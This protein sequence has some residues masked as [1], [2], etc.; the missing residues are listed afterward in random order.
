MRTLRALF[1]TILMPGTVVVVI[2]SM[3]LR[4]EAPAGPFAFQPLRLQGLILLVVG[5][6]ALFWCI[7]DFAVSG[8]GT[9]APVDPPRRLVRVGLYRYV[10]NPMYVAVITTLVG[11]ALFFGSRTL[12]IYAGFAWLVFHLFV[13][14]YEEPRLREL[15]G[16]DYVTYRAL[17]PR[18]IPRLRVAGARS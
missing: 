7:R 6:A 18:W 8:R 3:L 5:A 11:E 15:F 12:A 17:V 16:T 2:P 4:R 14:L 1:F 9:L 13:L 10:R